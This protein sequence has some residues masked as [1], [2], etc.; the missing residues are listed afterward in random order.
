MNKLFAFLL[1][2]GLS[3][4]MAHNAVAQRPQRTAKTAVKKAIVA[5]EKTLITPKKEKNMTQIQMPVLPYATNALEPVISQKTIEFHYGKHLQAYVNT[6]NQLVAGTDL[7]GK[8][9][10]EIVKAAPEGPLFNN[11]GQ[12]LN[13]QI[14]FLQF[15]APKA[16]NVPT[17]RIAEAINAQFGSFE[18]FKQEFSQAAATLFGAGWAW[19]SQDAEGKLVITKEQNAGNP[20]RSG[21]NPIFGI[22]VWEHAY[23]LD[24]QNRRVDHLAAIWDIVNWQAVEGL[25]K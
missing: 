23:Y 21:L 7:E 1:P 5:K 18:A 11:A 10:E 3:L 9:I 2:L 14:Y 15:Q 22:D 8:S 13:H 4:S 24:Y 12:T 17:G 19:L 6:T 16:G 25:M 20:V